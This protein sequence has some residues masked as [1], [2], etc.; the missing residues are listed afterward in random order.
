MKRVRSKQRPPIA[1]FDLTNIHHPTTDDPLIHIR[2]FQPRPPE[3]PLSDSRP[4]LRSAWSSHSDRSAHDVVVSNEHFRPNSETPSSLDTSFASSVATTTS[5]SSRKPTY[6]AKIEAIEKD[7]G[8]KVI[9]SMLLTSMKVIGAM[10]M[11][12]LSKPLLE[13]L[14]SVPYMIIKVIGVMMFF[15]PFR[16][17]RQQH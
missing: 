4:R 9:M 1:P 6:Q 11:M 17:R 14:L 7:W 8:F 5:S 3:R 12:L 2:K 13:V 15:G 16:T 10:M